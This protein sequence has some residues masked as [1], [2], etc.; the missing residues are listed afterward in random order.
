MEVFLNQEESETAGVFVAG[1]C[2][3]PSMLAGC[4]W[5]SQAIGQSS[6][7]ILIQ[8]SCLE[9][10]APGD[11]LSVPKRKSGVEI[12]GVSSPSAAY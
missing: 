4:L 5:C 7:S 12:E 10:W 3:A 8:T 11:S 6:L 1:S 9:C 2:P